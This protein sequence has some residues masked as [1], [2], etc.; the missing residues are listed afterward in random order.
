MFIGKYYSVYESYNCTCVFLSRKNISLRSELMFIG[1]I[2][3]FCFFLPQKEHN[4][5]VLGLVKSDEGFYQCIAEN[6]VGNAQAGAQLIILE[7]GKRDWNSKRDWL[8]VRSS[9]LSQD[10]SLQDTWWLI[11]CLKRLIYGITKREKIAI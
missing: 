2:I 7:H 6:D 10:L 9:Y 8:C 5:Q 4:L 1:W 3:K 11:N